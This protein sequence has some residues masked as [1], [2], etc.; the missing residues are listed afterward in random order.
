KRPERNPVDV[1]AG[2]EVALGN[3]LGLR[4]PL[5]GAGLAAGQRAG[6]FLQ[7]EQTVAEAHARLGGGH[8]QPR[9]VEALEVGGAV[10]TVQAGVARRVD[11]EGDVDLDVEAPGDGEGQLEVE[12]L[13]Q[14]GE[15]DVLQAE[16]GLDVGRLL[17]RRGGLVYVREAAE[18]LAG[19]A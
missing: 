19:P 17:P 2:A 7:P 9:Q 16:V 11:G 6:E 5:E 12:A 10:H 8:F 3:D 14:L 15:V 1:E 18:H 13:D 4:L